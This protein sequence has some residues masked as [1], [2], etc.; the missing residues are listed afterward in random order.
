[1]ILAAGPLI[2]VR[3]TILTRKTLGGVETDLSSRVLRADGQPLP[4]LFAAGEEAG[5]GDG[6]G[7]GGRGVM[8]GLPVGS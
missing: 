3:L 5:F 8:A 2:A 1:M 7:C 4:R 6:E